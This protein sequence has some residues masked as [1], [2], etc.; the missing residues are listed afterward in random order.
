MDDPLVISSPRF[1]EKSKKWFDL[2]SVKTLSLVKSMTWRHAR[3]GM[4]LGLLS[5]LL[6][7]D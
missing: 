3:A 7:N 6:T 2:E 1:S 4:H 5:K